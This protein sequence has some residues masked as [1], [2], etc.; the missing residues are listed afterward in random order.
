M[1]AVIGA[2]F[3]WS[4]FLH[5][6]SHQYAKQFARHGYKVAYIS[7]P[8]SPLHFLFAKDRKIL[9]EKSRYWYGGGKQVERGKIWAYVP[10]TFLP[11]YNKPLL[12]SKYAIKNSHRFM[13]P[14]LKKMLKK[15]DFEQADIIFLDEPFGHFLDLISHKTSILRIHDDIRYLHHE[16]QENFL[17]AAEKVAKKVD[18]VIV[19]SKA[20]ELQMKGMGIKKVLFLTN[21]ADFEHFFYGSDI[22]PEEYGNIPS[23]RVIYIGSLDYWFDSEIVE[24]AAKKL[25]AVSFILIGKPK[26]DISKLT[27]LSNVYALG[28]RNYSMLPP[29]LKNS[30]A[31]IIPFRS[32]KLV[33]SISPN[34]LYEYM[35]CGLPVV[36]THWEELEHIGSPALLALNQEEFVESIKKAL[37]EKNETKYVD[38]AR[39]NSWNHR[40]EEL[41]RTIQ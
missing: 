33:E 23:P 21:G 34:K 16:G 14:S 1:K 4:S 19:V 11:V 24:Y 7:E 8:I 20:L 17:A 12:R 39:M 35:A 5:I 38:F 31:G 2:H 18:L 22:I 6:G 9:K 28:A 13:L 40:F 10:Y 3:H 15:N 25:P 32:I 37:N 29:Y 36:S 41:L 27:S 26:I 30:N